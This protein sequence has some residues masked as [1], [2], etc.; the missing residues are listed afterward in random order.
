MSLKSKIT[1]L[2]RCFVVL[3][4][5]SFLGLLA[6]GY[7]NRSTDMFQVLLL[8]NASKPNAFFQSVFSRFSSMLFNEE[9]TS[10][11]DNGSQ[12]N[13]LS[14]SFPHLDP[15][16]PNVVRLARLDRP[17]L[18][19]TGA[20]PDLTY[21]QNNQLIVNKTRIKENFPSSVVTCKYQ[22]VIRKSNRDVLFAYSDIVKEFNNYIKLPS[23][24]EYFVV[25]CED[26]V[27]ASTYSS[28]SKS[29]SG[30]TST[31]HV[32][33][34]STLT[35]PLNR[36]YVN[37]SITFRTTYAPSTPPKPQIL[38]KT[39]YALI[40]KLDNLLETEYLRSQKRLIESSP[41]ETL[42]VI[43]I[44]FDGVSRYHFMRAM[45]KT[46]NLLVKDFQSFDMTKHSQV[47]KNTF[48]N[49]LGLFTGQSEEET[50][51]WW[52]SRKSTD[53]FD[54]LWKDFE[55][56]GY[57]TFFS[58]D[59]PKIGAFNFRLNGFYKVP[60]TYYNK[61]LSFA[62]DSDNGIWKAGRH[63]IGNRP[64]ILFQYDY[65]KSFLDAFPKKPL[66]SLQYSTRISH[67][68]V[69]MLSSVDEH[70]FN[71]YTELNRTGHLNN[72]LLLTFSDHGIRF[73][74]LR[75]THLGD[76][77]NRTPFVL[78]TFPTWFLKKYPDVARN[79]RT[80][81]GRLTTHFDTHAT[82]QDL[83][84]FKAGGY[85]P[86]HKSKH[87]I[88]LFQE[89]PRN[90]TCN[91]AAIPQEFCL[92]GYQ[93]LLNVDANSELS[94]FLSE[95]VLAFLNSKIDYTICQNLTIHK[96]LE[97]LR[98][99]DVNGDSGVAKSIFKLKVETVP[100]HGVFEAVVES[101]EKSTGNPWHKLSK[102]NLKDI[103]VKEGVDR[104]NMYR[105]QS[106]CAD[107]ARMKLFCYC[108]NLLKS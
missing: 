43:M 34:S 98:L 76:V 81:T 74:N 12:E 4:C 22:D 83:L 67:D 40:P 37:N 75:Y 61:A 26:R 8:Q 104:L 51:K 23:E 65:L 88:S 38:S 56:A 77:E 70:V 46:Y 101:V 64:E 60:T 93:N 1:S 19:C 52:D 50:R 28:T 99:H 96:I 13:G 5:A 102:D 89:I 49:F 69:T 36:S 29:Y 35:L 82:I 27:R 100:G 73:G 32:T 90:R 6:L 106:E 54:L 45:N 66:F 94:M 14:C 103:K 91:E 48:P 39:Y 47:G 71:F 85:S 2:N 62:L 79:L 30:S 57:R 17:T 80:N 107:D 11:L 16:H 53:E 42:N 86:I 58:E 3:I 18:S 84:Y 105:G 92:C 44:G 10:K 31:S 33:V 15:F 41:K 20:L 7:I 87:G 97:V 68:D 59:F 95:M 108:K 24:A 21:I 55:K 78:Y 25:T 9:A 63:C 72:T